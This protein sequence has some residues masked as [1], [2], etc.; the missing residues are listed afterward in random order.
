LITSATVRTCGAT[1]S[2]AMIVRIECMSAS[3]V[4][5]AGKTSAA[6]ASAMPE[7]ARSSALVVSPR[8]AEHHVAAVLHKLGATTRREAA[9]RASELE[10]ETRA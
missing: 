6:D 3:S 7:R 10:L 4:A 8:T 1:D 9:R 5:S 2:I